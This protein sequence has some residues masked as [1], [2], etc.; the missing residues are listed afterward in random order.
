[1]KRDPALRTLAVGD[2]RARI[3]EREQRVSARLPGESLVGV[4]RW[5]T[6]YRRALALREAA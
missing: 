2:L 1:M 4:K 5:L 3:A 6:R